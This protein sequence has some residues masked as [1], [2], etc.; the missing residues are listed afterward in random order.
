MINERIENII[1]GP[2]ADDGY[3]IVRIRY[4]GGL[5]RKN[6]QIMVER[7]GGKPVTI[8]DCKK[9]SN[10]LSTLFYV[11]E[12]VEGE[13]NLEV[14]STGIDRPL[15]KPEDF[16]KFKG[17]KVKVKTKHK[18]G[19]TTKFRGKLIDLKDDNIYLESE[20]GG[21]QLEIEFINLL[22]ANLDKE[23]FLFNKQTKPKKR[24]R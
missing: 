14:S 20:D 17:E 22:S 2:L 15:V 4:D 1:K 13:Y 7:Q 11:E 16:E 8:D 23:R 19:D 6:L 9:I 12:P 10:M 3:E 5:A 24:K 21:E 18:V